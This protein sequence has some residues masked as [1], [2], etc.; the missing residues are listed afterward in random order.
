MPRRGRFWVAL[1]LGFALATLAWVVARQTSAVVTAGQLGEL[2]ERRGE[3]EAREAELLA[4]IRVARSREVLIPRAEALGLRLPAD[5]EVVILQVPE[6][7]K[8]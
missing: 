1:W 3:L 2:R 7:G 4:R 6:P 8:R 5:S